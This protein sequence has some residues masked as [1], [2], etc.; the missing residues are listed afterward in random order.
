MRYIVK[1][2]TLLLLTLLATAGCSSTP[3]NDPYNPA[4]EQRSRADK[5]QDELSKETSGN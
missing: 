5:A 1:L 3:T 2:V 4:D